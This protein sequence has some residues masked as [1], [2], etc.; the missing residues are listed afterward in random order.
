MILFVDVGNQKIV[1]MVQVDR[2]GSFFFLFFLVCIYR[3]N[4]EG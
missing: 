4:F 2:S 1:V 3:T